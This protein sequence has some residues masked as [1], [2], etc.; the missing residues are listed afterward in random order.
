MI[1]AVLASLPLLDLLLKLVPLILSENCLQSL[2][3]LVFNIQH[4]R[5]GGATDFGNPLPGVAKNL[6]HLLFLLV[7]K[8]EALEGRFDAPSVKWRAAPYIRASRP[9][10]AIKVDS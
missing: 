2:S 1:K 4:L 9:S 10:L 6:V 5:R 8:V 3:R 7:G